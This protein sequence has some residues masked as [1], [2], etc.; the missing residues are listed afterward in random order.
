[1]HCSCTLVVLGYLN[2]ALSFQ[3]FKQEVVT[4]RNVV[5]FVGIETPYSIFSRECLLL[6]Q[7]KDFLLI[8]DGVVAHYQAFVHANWL[9][10]L[11]PGMS[12]NVSNFKT[13]LR[14]SV[15]YLFHQVLRILTHKARNLELP[16]ENLLV[17][18]GGV[19]I[20]E[21]EVATDECEHDNPATPNVYV[22]SEILF[23]CNHL[24]GCIAW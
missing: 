4:S 14:V 3:L 20:F 19:R 16:T 24:R 17:E 7:F 12:P 13:L 22:G 2:L 23:A 9:V 5:V 18:L 10:L 11:K 21:G 8:G 1:M 15:Q 6:Q